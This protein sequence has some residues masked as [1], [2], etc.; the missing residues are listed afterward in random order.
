MDELEKLLAEAERAFDEEKH[1]E[2]IELL[3]EDL[4]KKH[5]DASLYT[6]RARAH[7]RLKENDNTLRFAEE[8][9][10][11]NPKYGPAYRVRGNYWSEE[12]D[13]DKALFD[14]NKAIELDPKDWRAYINRGSDWY[15]K[16]DFDKAIS[17][18]SKSIELN[19][20]FSIGYNSRGNAWNA[21]KDYN[22]A[23]AD[24]NKAIELNPKYSVAYYNRAICW[25]NMGKDDNAM[26]DYDKSIE[27][28]PKS[29]SAYNNRGRI[30]H[31][32]EEYDKAITDYSKALEQDS[33]SSF[34][35]NN[36]GVAYAKKGLWDKA[37]SD[38][39]K[40]LFLNPSYALAYRNRGDAF[41]SRKEYEK[42]LT[43]YDRAIEL[44][45]ENFKWL[46][47]QRDKIREQLEEERRLKEKLKK[48]VPIKENIETLEKKIAGRIAK[49]RELAK[50]NVARVVH[51]TK[52]SVTEKIITEKPYKLQYSNEMYMNDPD[53]GKILFKYFD[54]PAIQQSFENGARHNES[55]VYLGSFLSA[56]PDGNGDSHED[57]LV[58][59]RTYG[60]NE[61]KEEAAGC[62]LVI[63]TAFF[64]KD[65]DK[66]SGDS[67]GGTAKALSVDHDAGQTLLK[68][69]YLKNDRIDDEDRDAFK[70][71]LTA[72][73]KQLKELLALKD[74]KKKDVNA[75]IDRIVFKHLSNICY[76]FKSSDYSFE[77]E[78]RVI[79]YV[80]KGS[81][82]IKIREQAAPLPPKRFYIE[83]SRSVLPYLRKIF[84]GAKVPDH[85]QW[86]YYFDY[87]LR[88]KALELTSD[89]QKPKLED[90]EILKSTCNFQ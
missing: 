8:A 56:M 65:G 40:A 21:K 53:E 69:I 80:P 18:Y 61:S 67:T 25:D 20:E 12:G 2:I 42:A 29:S 28:N 19:P 45:K 90:I 79:V 68:V 27:L 39:D 49:I 36:R 31:K 63:D 32:K 7:D 57:E 15:D 6:W 76:L 11:I 30:W 10:K 34:A 5:G 16:K 87:E 55:S 1:K 71:Q 72:L 3:T 22:R 43:D 23:M 47:Y 50:S 13:D 74:P 37:L 4:L 84:L 54:E 60:K 17:D 70:K 52:V 81:D 73:E 78:M 75:E 86:S 38:Y 14:Y 66:V 24:Y 82:V 89:D 46:T 44:D 59:W 51:Y 48:E 77:K 33:E 41:N 26:A 88:R 62:S 64:D 9:I 83:S 58:M 85:Q 35:Y